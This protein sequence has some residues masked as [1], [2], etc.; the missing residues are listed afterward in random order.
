MMT[1]HRAMNLSLRIIVAIAKIKPTGEV[2]LLYRRFIVI[3]VIFMMVAIM[4]WHCDGY[5]YK[6]VDQLW[7]FQDEIESRKSYAS[8]RRSARDVGARSLQPRPKC[9]FFYK[10][11]WKGSRWY[12]S[13][14]IAHLQGNSA[15]I[16]PFDS[17]TEANCHSVFEMVDEMSNVH[18]NC[19]ALTVP[20][21]LQWHVTWG[22]R[23]HSASSDVAPAF[24]L[25]GKRENN[26]FNTYEDVPLPPQFKCSLVSLF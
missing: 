25:Q 16:R 10:G 21:R 13:N 2:E 20:D 5:W 22:G 19:L 9:C 7:L 12:F 6:I 15:D 18:D 23:R 3:G 8:M 4:V 1:T 26:S 14:M 24:G 11:T 17:K